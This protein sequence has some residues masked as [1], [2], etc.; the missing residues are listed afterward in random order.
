MD[1]AHLYTPLASMSLWGS[2]LS[3][4][5]APLTTLCFCRPAG[6]DRDEEPCGS[7]LV[8]SARQDE[9]PR[10][11]RTGQG[12]GQSQVGKKNDDGDSNGDDGNGDDS[13][14]D[15]EGD[16]ENKDPNKG[17][18]TGQHTKRACADS[19][20]TS[21][22]GESEEDGDGDMDESARRPL[23]FTDRMVSF[24]SCISAA[25]ARP[26]MSADGNQAHEYALYVA[27][28]TPN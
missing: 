11:G 13:G 15:S 16:K 20:M 18:G 9:V 19:A 12:A 22:A 8:H 27:A 17:H 3:A 2:G 26:L 23:A 4:P 21:F 5:T 28:Q 7:Q 24:S 14:N 25:S 6:D 10:P 1:F